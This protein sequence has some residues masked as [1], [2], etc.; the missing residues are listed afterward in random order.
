MPERD[1]RG[2]PDEKI[3]RDRG[4]GK[5]HHPRSDADEIAAAGNPRHRRQ[6]REHQE[7]ARR[8]RCRW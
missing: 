1:Q 4:D 3:E 6:Q 5:N 2:V 7:D 8:Q